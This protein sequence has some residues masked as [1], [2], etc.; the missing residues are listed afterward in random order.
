MVC[1]DQFLALGLN[2]ITLDEG[3]LREVTEIARAYRD[4]RRPLQDPVRLRLERRTRR[5]HL[6]TATPSPGGWVNSVARCGRRNGLREAVKDEGSGYG[7]PHQTAAP[8][9]T[10]SLLTHWAPPSPAGGEG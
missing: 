6:P 1:N 9:L 2:P 8:P 4:P 10:L 5:R 3:L 7:Q